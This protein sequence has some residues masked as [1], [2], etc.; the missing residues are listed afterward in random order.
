MGDPPCCNVGGCALN[1]SC[2]FGVRQTDT[3]KAVCWYVPRPCCQLLAC[4]ANLFLAPFAFAL[5]WV[6]IYA[7]PCLLTTLHMA[8]SKCFCALCGGF[9]PKYRDPWF[10]AND[11]SVGYNLLGRGPK[12]CLDFFCC[13]CAKV[14]CICHNP[15]SKATIPWKR[16]NEVVEARDGAGAGRAQLFEGK[17]EAN[18]VQQGGLGDCWLLSAI[19]SIAEAHPEIVR[20]LFITN[21]VEPCGIYRI[22]LYDVRFERWT[23]VTIDDRIPM[24]DANTAPRFTQ[25]NG[26][27]LWVLLLEK[28]FAKLW[29]SYGY[30]EGGHVILALQSFTGN[31]GVLMDPKV[32]CE[33]TS[34]DQFFDVI[35]GTLAHGFVVDVRP[36]NM[37]VGCSFA[38]AEQGLITGHAYSI[39][40]CATLQSGAKLL[41][42]RN[43]HAQGEWTGKY[44]DKD[45]AWME[46][47]VTSMKGQRVDRE[48][49]DGIFWMC[50]ED[51]VAHSDDVY[52]VGAS[53]SVGTETME[54]HEGLG[55]CGPARGCA[56]GSLNYCC[57]G[58]C[59]L[60]CFPE[61]RGTL[62][63]LR[64]AGLNFGAKGWRVK[65][66]HDE[67]AAG[68][69]HNKAGWAENLGGGPPVVD[70]PAGDEAA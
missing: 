22:R 33:S 60:T 11:A 40:D 57:G 7:I 62:T 56:G 30:L 13:C 28:A 18:D 36:P 29:G 2:L 67:E 45:A 20:S 8:L 65:R 39:L 49:D 51:F 4:V 32:Y 9:F 58:G 23:T 69:K 44:S 38:R 70:E 5:G 21:F 24:N 19:A 55:L 68:G 12:P 61:R 17:I 47:G 42:I 1:K 14:V 6:R 34:V 35:H 64:D 54:F 43:P 63:V 31:H 53:R 37:L 59:R 16:A 48:S 46:A 27:E 3:S 10:P 66:Y 41:K 52:F 50:I 25:P 26:P 15:C